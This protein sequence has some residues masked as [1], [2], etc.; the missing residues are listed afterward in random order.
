[1]ND[2][3][4]FVRATLAGISLEL[5]SRRARESFWEYRK[6][7]NPKLKDGW[8]HRELAQELQQ[9][10]VELVNGRAPKLVVQAPPQHGK[11]MAI[12]DFISWI[13]GH[14]PDLRT[15]YT[16]FSERLGIRANL[17]LQRLFD[18]EVY[19]Y[20]FG[21]RIGISNAVAISAQTLRNRE[22][23]EYKNHEGYFRNTTVCGS[24]TGESLDLGVI[25][26]PIKGRDQANSDTVRN[27]TW[28]WLT[29]DFFT[30]FSEGAGLLCITT[31]WH[32]DDPIGR[33]IASDKSVNVI[34]YKAIATD[35]EKHRTI[36]EPLFPE[37]K[38]L[39]FLERIRA[40]MS[41]SSFESLYQQ[42]PTL[43]DGNMF[44]PDMMP[45]V[46]ALPEALHYVRS[47][48]LAATDGGGAY[49]AGTKLGIEC[50]GSRVYICDV[51]RIQ[52]SPDEVEKLIKNTAKRDGHEVVIHIPQDPGQ[53]GKAQVA[54]YAKQLMGYSVHSEPVTGDKTLNAEPMAAQINVGNVTMLRATWNDQFVDEMRSFP[55]GK[56]KDQ[57]DAAALGFRKILGLASSTELDIVS[58][59]LSAGDNW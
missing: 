59:L 53:A 51:V 11:S 40:V 19:K 1:M 23:L 32:I 42:S 47:W 43:A 8:F 24:I 3:A 49:T 50:D 35:D 18:G 15:I 38:S 12:I 25:D 54:Y 7:I 56:Y 14:N 55:N 30:R 20:I 33:L 6:L 31:R 2:R 44:K 36:G 28:E 58:S 34:T 41:P 46:D 29:D 13:A 39:E 52:G 57:I 10:Y 48:D 9:F 45:V 27:R 26:D 5:A 16:S 22:I 37:H 21:E 17:R 4:N